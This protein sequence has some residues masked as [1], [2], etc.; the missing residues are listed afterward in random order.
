MP[1][2]LFLLPF[3]LLRGKAQF[4]R[5]IACRVDLDVSC[6]PYETTLLRYL[7]E[8]RQL[9]RQIFLATAADERIA[10]KVAGHVDL[11]FSGSRK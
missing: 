10:A 5:Q 8:Q 9:G 3:W 6:L 1:L 7:A 4:K 2:Y 11:F